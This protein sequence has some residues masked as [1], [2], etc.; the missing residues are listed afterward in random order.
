[1]ERRLRKVSFVFSHAH[2][3]L[4]TLQWIPLQPSSLFFYEIV[5]VLVHGSVELDLVDPGGPGLF[6]RG[7]FY[8]ALLEESAVRRIG[9]GGPCGRLL[10]HVAIATGVHPRHDLWRSRGRSAQLI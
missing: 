8:L 3:S 1:M 5:D 4:L 7:S 9:G 2:E 6:S 10:P